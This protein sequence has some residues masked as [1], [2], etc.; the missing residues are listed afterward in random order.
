MPMTPNALK[1]WAKSLLEI[2]DTWDH[3]EWLVEKIRKAGERRPTPIEMR[4][5]YAQYHKP[6]D[7]LEPWSRELDLSDVM[8]SYQKKSTGD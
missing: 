7:G 8:P 1:S 2:A 3:A 4:R 5:V 6:A